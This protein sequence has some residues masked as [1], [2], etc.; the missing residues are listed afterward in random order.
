MLAVAW[1]LFALSVEV[2]VLDS[3]CD[4]LDDDDD[5]DALDPN[6]V[7]LVVEER[8]VS[9]SD[10]VFVVLSNKSEADFVAP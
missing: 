5:D 7:D 6:V 9:D 2:S 1:I 10:W 3:D 8:V 4:G